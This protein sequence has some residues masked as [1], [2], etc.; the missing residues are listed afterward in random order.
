MPL[1]LKSSMSYKGEEK[2]KEMKKV[3]QEIWTKIEKTNEMYKARAN[4]HCKAITFKPRDLVWLH[5]RKGRFPSRRQRKLMPR[6]DSPF[7]VLEKVNDNAYKLELRRDMGVSPT[8]NIGD[9]T[10]YLEDED[11]KDDLRANHNQEGKDEA[12]FMPILGQESTQ[13]PLSAQK[14]HSK[15]LGPCTDLELQ[16]KAHPKHLGCVISLFW[17]VQE[18]S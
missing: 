5:L 15:G 6:G 3:H 7:K 11:D 10:P 1:P 9:L 2:A 4:K 12:N 18:V 16:F 13:V 8:F 14:L 17:E